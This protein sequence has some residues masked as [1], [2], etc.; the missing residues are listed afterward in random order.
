MAAKIFLSSTYEDLVD[1]RAGVETLV[2]K[3]GK[4]VIGMEHFG[5][6]SRPSLDTCLQEIAESD[7]VIVLV[8]A[9]YG[10][11]SENG[12]SYTQRE[13]EQARAL[14]IS[15]LAFVQAEPTSVAGAE[16]SLRDAFIRWLSDHYTI[17]RFTDPL[18][19][20]TQVAA[21]LSHFDLRL[22]VSGDVDSWREIIERARS[23]AD[24]DCVALTAHNVDR[25]YPV[26]RVAPNYETRINTPI[27]GAG[28]SGANT[29][30]GLGRMGLRIAA[31]G[32]VGNDPDGAFLCDA[33]IADHVEPM[34]A[35]CR[36]PQQ[37]TGTTLVF[38][39]PKGHRSIYVHP[40]A[41]EQFATAAKVQPYLSRLR[42]AI[43]STRVLHYSSFTLAPE[44]G[45]Q[46]SL[47]KELPA[48]AILSLTPGALYCK[49]GLDRLAPL[50][51]RANV[52]Y[53]Y[54]QQLDELLGRQSNVRRSQDGAATVENLEHLYAW[55]KRHGYHEPLAVIIKNASSAVATAPEQLRGAVGR[56]YLEATEPTQALLGVEVVVR[57]GTGAGDASAAG[58]LWAILRGKPL[59]YALDIAYVFARS[60]AREYGART[61]LPTDTQL[62]RRWTNWVGAPHRL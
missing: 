52:L 54:E 9:R 56:T 43:S 37:P 34:L 62:R 5:A 47:L 41:N 30:C 8:G 10:T 6:R 55:K 45:M 29:A 48:G 57:D 1:Y 42:S 19:L 31:A 60:A 32:L 51:R 40:G 17:A 44:R 2:R 13:V 12:K 26:D 33:L 59:H 23:A 4:L 22:D 11:I 7:V 27:I 53:L 24:W 46:A 39:D 61:G 15:V 16:A 18:S 58:L 35:P 21:A 38:A 3:F 28:G 20:V 14:N 36:N 25:L 49:L 50:L